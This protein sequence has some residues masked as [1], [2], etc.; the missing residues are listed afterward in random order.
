MV[1]SSTV[2]RSIEDCLG[3]ISISVDYTGSSSHGLFQVSKAEI[4]IYPWASIDPLFKNKQK[5][6]PGELEIDLPHLSTWEAYRNGP[7]AGVQW[8]TNLTIQISRDFL[9]LLCS[10]N[11]SKAL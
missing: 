3:V 10:D 8:W 11:Q 6:E 7:S 5:G 9:F 2:A 4:W 1:R